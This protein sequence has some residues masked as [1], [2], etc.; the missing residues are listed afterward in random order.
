MQLHICRADSTSQEQQ[1]QAQLLA[2]A[3]A[4]SPTAMVDAAALASSSQGRAT[5]PAKALIDHFTGAS[6]PPSTAAPSADKD[7]NTSGS[8]VNASPVAAAK[9]SLASGK[10]WAANA[11]AVR[12]AAQ[13]VDSWAGSVLDSPEPQVLRSALMRI[14]VEY[15]R[16]L[17]HLE[18]T[19]RKCAELAHDNNRC[20]SVCV[21]GGGGWGGGG[22]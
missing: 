5:S 18:K 11:A 12:A 17:V 19:S 21:R 9:K 15:K 1:L 16:T 13:A 7:N 4:G 2:V 22:L 14:R 6:K 8:S 20:V 3:E 10:G